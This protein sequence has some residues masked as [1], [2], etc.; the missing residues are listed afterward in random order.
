MIPDELII[1]RQ[2]LMQMVQANPADF[3]S[4]I[5]IA[6]IEAKIWA[7]DPAQ[8]DPGR[9]VA[10]LDLA[11]A[12]LPASHHPQIAQFT[13]QLVQQGM[14]LAP[15]LQQGSHIRLLALLKGQPVPQ[16]APAAAA[17]IAAP[18][19]VAAVR[20]VPTGARVVAR[21]IEVGTPDAAQLK[22]WMAEGKLEE[23][24]SAFVSTDNFRTRRIILDKVGETKSP[25]A[26]ACLVKMLGGSHDEKMNDEILKKILTY[27][28]ALLESQLVYDP[29]N[30]RDKVAVVTIFAALKAEFCVEPLT[31]AL[32]DSDY[33]VKVKA[34]EGLS[35]MIEASPEWIEH[36]AGIIITEP[37]NSKKVR[38]AAATA[39]RDI[40]SRESLQALE[41][42][43]KQSPAD[44]ALTKILQSAGSKTA[45]GQLDV[46]K[47]KMQEAQKKQRAQS[48]KE[49]KSSESRF[50]LNPR[51][52]G[53]MAG[54]LGLVA[55]V[56]YG[57]FAWSQSR[58]KP[59]PPPKHQFLEPTP[60][61]AER[62]RKLQEGLKDLQERLKGSL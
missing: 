21:D 23:L 41:K 35:T 32:E 37:A 33:H 15:I 36:L 42:A 57:V 40:G 27:D 25:L 22:A 30:T 6:Q 54:M 20:A 58:L 24:A 8:A 38:A 50:A 51:M 17:P 39:L 16:G 62:Q 49:A 1:E 53:M 60:D 29:G 45:S 48:A 34:I 52:I 59:A 7:S 4:H 14:P 12:S 61:A 31:Q 28:P 47:A 44:P 26:L 43:I 10:H 9:V 46:R 56:G 5:K 13:K 18:Q 19:P 2:S 11:L 55:F 3:A